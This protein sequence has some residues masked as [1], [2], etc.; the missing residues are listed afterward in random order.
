MRFRVP[1]FIEIEDKIFGPLTLRQF[2]YLA[3]GVGASTAFVVLLPL[4]IGVA[5]SLV[6]MGFSGTLAFV[7][8]NNRPFIYTVESFVKFIIQPKLYIWKKEEQ[9]PAKKA[10]ELDTDEAREALGLKE[11]VPRVSN[12]NLRDMAWGLGVNDSLYAD[13][14]KS[15]QTEVAKMQ[16]VAGSANP[17]DTNDNDTA[18][19]QVATENKRF[20][21][22]TNAVEKQKE[23][24]G[25][26][27]GE[28]TERDSLNLQM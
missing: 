25:S 13:S 7:E 27:G 15:R 18:G 11:T 2:L 19:D 16:S 24:S 8:V 17:K 10:S 23:A 4:Y 3:G 9:Q 22:Q 1:Q 26:T 14:E 12:S 6:V 5:L 20:Q 21:Q 28:D